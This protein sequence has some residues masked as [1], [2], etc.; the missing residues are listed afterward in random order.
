[1]GPVILWSSN[2]GKIIGGL[3]YKKIGTCF[4][5]RF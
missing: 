1:M 4:N 3:D 5:I 2:A